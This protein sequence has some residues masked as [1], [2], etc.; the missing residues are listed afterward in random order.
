MLVWAAVEGFVPLA[1]DLMLHCFHAEKQF[2][3]K[4]GENRSVLTQDVRVDQIVR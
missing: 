1:L 4:V 3:T 2:V